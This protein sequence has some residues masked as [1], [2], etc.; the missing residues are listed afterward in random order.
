MKIF[1]SYKQTGVSD[2]E[3]TDKLWKIR[4]ILSSMWHESFIYYFDADFQQQTP[5]EIIEYAKEKIE[6]S[7]IIISFINYEW[8]SEW[9]MEELWIAFWLDKKV[10]ILMNTQ[11][12]SQY[13][14]SYWLSDNT[15]LFSEFSEIKDILFHNLP[16]WQK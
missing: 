14:L 9:M 5:K 10:M 12:E 4:D 13:Y 7:D 15:V 16:L 1:I 2:N 8:K 3:L 6:E 11:F